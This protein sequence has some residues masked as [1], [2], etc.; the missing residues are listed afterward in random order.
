MTDFIRTPEAN[1]E[2]LKDFSFQ[3]HYHEWQDLC[4]HY[5][6]EGPA[7]APVML[8]LHGM[9]T[10][11]YLYRDI[12][13]LFVEAGYRCIAPDHM[14]FGRSDKPIDIHW[15]TI[16]RHT[17]IL[18]SLITALDLQEITLLCQDWGGPT[19]LAQAVYMP[20]RF[21]RLVIMN[22]WLHHPQYEYSHAIR[23]WNQNWHEGGMFCREKPNVGVLMTMSSGLMQREEAFPA[24]VEGTEPDLSGAAAEMYKAYNA[25]V[26]G[27][28]DEAYNGLRRFPLSIPLDS[29]DNGNAAAQAHH[30][31]TLLEWDKA[32]NFV[33]GCADD[34]FLEP[35]GRTWAERMN[36]SFDAIP[37]AGHFLQ[38]THGAEVAGFVLE[39]MA[40]G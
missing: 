38:N 31:R 30:Y 27:L 35:W 32:V 33:W 15:Y 24:I 7:D 14:G 36:A 2:G 21:D 29:P 23:N 4:M 8:L 1:F 5:L 18:T 11:S 37:D 20:E 25:P 28:P 40:E 16:A 17:E 19:G 13:P 9:P 3:P 34:V 10:W 22:T 39:H 6:D 12:I 26:L